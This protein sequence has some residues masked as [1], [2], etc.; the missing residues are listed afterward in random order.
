MHA[1]S[2]PIKTS[3]R[4][5]LAVL[6]IALMAAAPVLA[7]GNGAPADC[8]HGRGGHGGP[9]AHGF[10][11]GPLG[12]H[13]LARL[14]LSDEQWA[15]IRELRATRERDDAGLREALAAYRKAMEEAWNAQTP[16]KAEI[17]ARWEEGAELRRQLHEKM[18]DMRL[19]VLSVLTPEQREKLRTLA[20][21]EPGC[22]GKGHGGEHHGMGHHGKG[23]GPGGCGGGSDA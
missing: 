4:L 19:A 17:M 23:H 1:L 2:A 22:G 15:Q 12:P 20:A 3:F 21:E 16:D 13:L 9:M 18:V 6:A 8:P 7:C 14:D 5:T 10:G 11:P